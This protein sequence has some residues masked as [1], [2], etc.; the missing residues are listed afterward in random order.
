MEKAAT[1]FQKASELDPADYQAIIQLEN[2]LR[3]LGRK[4][5][6]RRVSEQAVRVIERHIQHEPGDARAFYLGSGAALHL[7]D[8]ERALDWIARALTIDPEET[9]VLYN[10]A[11]TYTHLGETDTALDLL[12]KAIRNGFGYKEWLEH[13]PDFDPIRDHPRFHSLIRSFS[14]A[15]IEL[16]P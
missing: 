9:A 16:H 4:D 6:A 10:A 5:E 14:A 3:A 7:G 13:D 8:R 11:C 2:C 12:E 15:P 1:L